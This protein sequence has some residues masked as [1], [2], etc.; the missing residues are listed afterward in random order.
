MIGKILTDSDGWITNM[1]TF[2]RILPNA[3]NV[4]FIT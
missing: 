4:G 2:Y 3:F 1:D